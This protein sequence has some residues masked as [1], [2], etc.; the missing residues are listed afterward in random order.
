M[1]SKTESIAGLLEGIQRA[2][3]QKEF[4]ILQDLQML[5]KAYAQASK[6]DYP[7][8]LAQL[9]QKYKVDEAAEVHAALLRK[10]RAGDIEAMRLWAE[11]EKDSQAAGEEVQI[12][13]DIKA[14]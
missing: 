8:L 9:I 12:I 4:N 6:R 10:C 1:R 5:Q 13:D 14:K 3:E 2:A 7:Q 11:L